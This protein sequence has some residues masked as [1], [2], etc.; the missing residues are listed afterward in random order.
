MLISQLEELLGL[1]QP[2]Q[3]Q[4]FTG[5]IVFAQNINMSAIWAINL[6]QGRTRLIGD[7]A[8]VTNEDYIPTTCVE[9][10][11]VAVRAGSTRKLCPRVLLNR[12]LLNLNWL[13]VHLLLPRWA[14]AKALLSQI[15]LDVTD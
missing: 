11:N 5:F 13:L 3:V 15:P 12:G 7:I 8:K 1:P 14:R 6:P 4:R 2:L 9:A 10:S